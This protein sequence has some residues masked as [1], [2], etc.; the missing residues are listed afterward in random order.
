MK[1]KSNPL[2]DFLLKIT[3]AVHSYLYKAISFLAIRKEGG[4]HPKH[5][6]LNYH[7]F[8]LENILS[9]SRVLDVGCSSGELTFDLA[10]KARKVVGIDLNEKYLQKAKQKNNA[11]NIEYILGDGASYDFKEKFNFAV[12]SNVLEHIEKREDFLKKISSIADKI[13]IRAP[14]LTRDWLSVYKKETG[15]WYKLDKTH[16]IEY[17][18]E[19]FIWEIEKAGLKIEKMEI[20][21]GEIYAII[22]KKN[23]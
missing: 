3:L 1:N 22:S 20:N 15:V 21:F 12:L 19:Q 11:H 13:L 14:L 7:Q 8:F 4:K 17:T 2:F 18:K 23:N 5:R 6:I 10:K 9:Q 16:F